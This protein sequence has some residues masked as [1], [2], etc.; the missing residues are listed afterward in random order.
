M[1]FTAP[2]VKGTIQV[3]FDAGG[4]APGFAEIPPGADGTVLMADS[5]QPKGLK[6][7]TPTATVDPRDIMRFAMIHNVGVTGGG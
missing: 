6:Y 5:T 7:G 4:G 1:S 3:G 2:K